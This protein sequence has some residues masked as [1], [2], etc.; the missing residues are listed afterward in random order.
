MNQQMYN[1]VSGL[2]FIGRALRRELGG[3]VARWRG[4]SGA[5]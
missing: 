5:L 1:L 2:F 4:H 3:A